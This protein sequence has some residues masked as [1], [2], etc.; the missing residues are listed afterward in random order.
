MSRRTSGLGRGLGEL[1]ADNSPEIRGGATV[2]R[3][4]EN[5]ETTITPDIADVVETEADV[6]A[7]VE[8][9]GGEPAAVT[10]TGGE[11]A[12]YEQLSIESVNSTCEK[13]K[14]TAHNVVDGRDLAETAPII[15]NANSSVYADGEVQAEEFSRQ[16]AGEEVHHTRRSLKALFRNYK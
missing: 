5:G 12:T 6:A 11:T 13:D 7:V 15:I 14:I 9:V 10:L 16:E 1:L 8:H 4:D 3:R 2:V